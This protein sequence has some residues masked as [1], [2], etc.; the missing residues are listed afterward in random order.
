MRRA[1]VCLDAHQPHQRLYAQ[2]LAQDHPAWHLSRD[3]VQAARFRI[4][5]GF[6][7]SPRARLQQPHE[8]LCQDC[9]QLQGHASELVVIDG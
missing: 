7:L 2:V 9:L 1:R 4:P 5:R 6:S 8:H 3:S